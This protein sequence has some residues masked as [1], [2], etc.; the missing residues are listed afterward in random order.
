[1]IYYF[2]WKRIYIN[3]VGGVGANIPNLDITTVTNIGEYKNWVIAY[4]ENLED[5]KLLSEFDPVL[6]TEG[7]AKGLPLIGKTQIFE[8]IGLTPIEG[9]W[10]DLTEQELS[11]QKEAQDYVYKMDA[12]DNINKD[13]GD[14]QDLIADLSKR[15]DLIERGLC[16]LILKTKS[17]NPLIDPDRDIRYE[18]YANIVISGSDSGQYITRADLENEEELVQTLMMRQITIAGIIQ[19]YKTKVS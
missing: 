19:D 13:V 6:I 8:R 5:F 16:Y 9:S 12:R 2:R 15:V 7:V 4:T 1:M 3:G 11:W 17:E 18:T 10:R 14:I